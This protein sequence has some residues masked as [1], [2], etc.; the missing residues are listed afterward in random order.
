MTR[1]KRKPDGPEELA[2]VLQKRGEFNHETMG[3]ESWAGA[4]QITVHGKV[5]PGETKIATLYREILEELGGKFTPDGRAQE[6]ITSNMVEIG[7]VD[8]PNKAIIHYAIEILPARLKLIRLNAS[9]G[10]LRLVFRSDLP[11]IQP[12]PNHA[13]NKA[14]GVFA[15]QAIA[16][17]PDE[18]EALKAAFAH[19][20]KKKT[21]D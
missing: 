8:K 20:E 2:A 16:M 12:L 21:A 10:G 13:A 17:F 9:T 5:E 7:R 15:R 3:P 14:D 19:F 4:C 6:N 18:I 1:M 11:E